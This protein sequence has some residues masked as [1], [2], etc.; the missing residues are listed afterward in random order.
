[1]TRLCH[2]FGMAVA[3][4][5]HTNG[6]VVLTCSGVLTGQELI[7]AMRSLVKER[8]NGIRCFITD[9]TAVDLATI[10]TDELRAIVDEDKLLSAFAKPGMRVAVVAPLDFGFGLFRMWEVFAEKTGWRIL[11][12]RSRALADPWVQQTFESG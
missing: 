7:N 10:S 8:S 12:F 4:K 11:V 2:C 1:M 3:A 5:L 9:L 6:C